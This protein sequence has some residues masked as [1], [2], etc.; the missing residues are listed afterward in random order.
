MALYLAKSMGKNIFA[1]YQERDGKGPVQ[2]FTPG[3]SASTMIESFE[4][5]KDTLFK[6]VTKAADRAVSF[7]GHRSGYPGCA[8]SCGTDAGCE[9]GIYF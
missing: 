6:L 3:H 5:P 7:T 4:S 9:P 1:M 2:G 8:G